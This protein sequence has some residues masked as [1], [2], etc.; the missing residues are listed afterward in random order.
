MY[1]SQT[2]Y[3]QDKDHLSVNC[4]YIVIGRYATPDVAHNKKNSKL[5]KN[6][7]FRC[8]PGHLQV[9]L[10]MSATHRFN[11]NQH[12]LLQQFRLSVLSYS[13]IRY[14][15]YYRQKPIVRSYIVNYI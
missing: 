7:Y 14:A 2:Q 3:R 5:K 10:I 15:I 4:V 9:V 13:N 11:H 8:P 6:D 12:N 1:H